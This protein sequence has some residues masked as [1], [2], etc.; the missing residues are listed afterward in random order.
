MY[1]IIGRYGR[2]RE[3]THFSGSIEKITNKYYTGSIIENDKEKKIYV[4]E[5]VLQNTRGL[6]LLIPFNKRVHVMNKEDKSGL[7]G[8]YSGI[9]EFYREQIPILKNYDEAY[10]KTKK[11]TPINYY[12]TIL[13]IIKK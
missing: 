8:E 3:E 4:Y 9:I 5:K 2:T 12:D 13:E 10:T 6:I 11:Y 1:S 7:A